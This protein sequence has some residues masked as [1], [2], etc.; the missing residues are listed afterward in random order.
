MSYALLAMESAAENMKSEDERVQIHDAHDYACDSTASKRARCLSN[1]K[2][3][4]RHPR[5]ARMSMQS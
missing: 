1:S 3:V 2:W 5:E 4:H